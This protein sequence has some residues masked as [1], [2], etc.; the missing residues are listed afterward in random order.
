MP[1]GQISGTPVVLTQLAANG[2]GPVTV[3]VPMSS[4]G[5]RNLT[6]LGTPPIT[7]GKAVWKANLSGQ[8]NGRAIA[9][10]PVSQLPFQVSATYELNGKKMWAKNIVGKSGHL[11]V[12]YVIKNITTKATT[13]TFKNV[14]GVTEKRTVQVPVPMAAVFDVTFPADFTNLKAPAA[15]VNGNGNGTVGASW[16]LF[17]F[18][19]LGGVRQ[20]VTYQAQVSDA[21]IP[22]ATLEA[23]S[24]PPASLK[25]LRTVHEP[26]A[27]AVPVVTVGSHLAS[28]QTAF[29]MKL[30]QVAA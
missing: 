10:F 1:D 11:K 6:G 25:P 30:Q 15:G 3:K 21:V 17:F 9:H 26:G 29:R 14:F 28:L 13:V 27:P 4:A 24:I 12:T 2:S 18:N 16:T 19:P 22:S 8:I 7:D 5:F 20:S 23:Q